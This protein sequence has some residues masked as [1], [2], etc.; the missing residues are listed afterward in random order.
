MSLEQGRDSGSPG[1]PPG[2]DTETPGEVFLEGDMWILRVHSSMATPLE[3]N[4]VWSLVLLKHLE[5]SHD[6]ID[7]LATRRDVSQPGYEA[8]VSDDAA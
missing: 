5:Q 4:L 6:G 8:Q 7:V 2:F 1:C 3:V